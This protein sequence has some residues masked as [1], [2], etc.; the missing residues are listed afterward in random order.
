MT[1]WLTKCMEDMT[2]AEWESL[3]DGC[4]LCC[5]LRLEDEDSAEI[6]LTQTACRY[7]D[8]RTHRC[9]DYD[10][11]VANVPACVN[12]TPATVHSMHWLPQS[13]AYRLVAGGYDL[14]VWHHLKCGDPTRV[15]THGPSMRGDLTHEDAR[16]GADA[17]ESGAKRRPAGRGG[18]PRRQASPKGPLRAGRGVP[19][20]RGP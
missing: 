17:D 15:H 19:G 14:P 2:H 16:A 10:N 18:T 20:R 4:G 3:C 1:F 11:R 13:C 12:V 7:L 9:T 8:L 5:Q 6:A